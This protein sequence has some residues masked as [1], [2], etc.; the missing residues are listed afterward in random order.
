M[1]RAAGTVTAG[2]VAAVLAAGCTTPPTD[3]AGSDTMVLKLATIDGQINNN[4]YSFGP[5]TF[6]RALSEVS[7]DRIQVD[8]ATTYGGEDAAAEA[9]LVTAIAEGEVDGGWPATRA[10]AAAGI[11]GLAA[12][13]AP[14]TVTSYAAEKDLAVGTAA[15]LAMA[16]LGGSGVK[17]LGLA[18]GPL[19]RPFGAETFPISLE[20][21]HGMRFRSY[22]SPVQTDT[23]E[24]LRGTAVQ[25]GTD[26]P[27]KLQT[28]QID[29][30]E[31]DLA[32]YLANGHGRE[33]GKVASDIVLWPKMYV[34][35]IN[36]DLWDGL[37]EQQRSW[38]Q[39]AADR[40]IRASVDSD[41]PEDE[42][43]RQL[44][45][46]GVRFKPAGPGGLRALRQAVRP[47]LDRL[48]DE[49]GEAEL[50][51][52]VL[53]AADRHPATDSVTVPRACTTDPGTADDPGIPTTLAPIPDGTYR[54]QITE[55]QVRAAGYTNSDGTSGTWTLEITDGRWSESCRPIDA[56]GL[57]CG[58]T[59]ADSVLDAGSFYGDAR[60]VWMVS[61]PARLAQAT[62]CRLPAD[63]TAGHCHPATPATRLRWALDGDDLVF[64]RSGTSL[65]FL[66][67]TLGPYVRIG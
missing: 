44:C 22:N 62:G 17:G 63:G 43:A 53:A 42:I 64:Q 16:G 67:T 18:V 21:W 2:I 41:Y 29:G 40:A 55:Q 45:D 12:L 52:Q 51:A 5:A 26:W 24:S 31:M 9:D 19:R 6:V 30:I 4:G 10:F 8:V 25:A 37:N 15:R 39:A 13:E 32:Q 60:V 56:P 11:E 14:L 46:R 27:A 54:K 36:Q 34:L 58:H 38:I 20:D 1:T 3:K 35:A 47:V 49:P 7:G 28:G 48:A 23:I 57:D 61:E 66:E 59:V 50:L 65:G 33:A